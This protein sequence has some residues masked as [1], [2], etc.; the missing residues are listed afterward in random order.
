MQG[1]QSVVVV[2]SRP[3]FD[4]AEALAMLWFGDRFRCE[5]LSHADW[6][7]RYFRSI[8]LAEDEPTVLAYRVQCREDVSECLI[9]IRESAKLLCP[10][11]LFGIER[12]AGLERFFIG[13]MGLR[14]RHPL[15]WLLPEDTEYCSA[16]EIVAR[17]R[18]RMPHDWPMLAIP[19]VDLSMA[20][21]RIRD[22]CDDEVAIR[23]ALHGFGNRQSNSA[24]L[25]RYLE[26]LRWI[27]SAVERRLEGKN[28]LQVC[29]MLDNLNVS[30][31]AARSALEVVSRT[32]GLNRNEGEP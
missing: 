22:L 27:R 12:P 11:I 30:P 1:L 32:V 2:S 25:G 9:S 10:L 13:S 20:W 7:D 8:E 26:R 15:W 23:R 4:L 31:D 21:R 17:L 3:D 18:Y 24:D 5:V 28:W 6:T 29:A 16:D 14:K 19:E